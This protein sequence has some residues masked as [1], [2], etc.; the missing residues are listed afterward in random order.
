MEGKHMTDTLTIFNGL[1]CNHHSSDLTNVGI[2]AE[3]ETM[4][5]VLLEPLKHEA[6]MG[7]HLPGT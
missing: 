5:H 2:E 6:A 4:T 7:D 3:T 1:S